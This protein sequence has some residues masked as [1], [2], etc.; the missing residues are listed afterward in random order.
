MRVLVTGGAGFIGRHV[1]DALERHDVAVLDAATDG[2]VR[3]AEALDD[4]LPGVD[5]V[6]HLAA[7]VGLGVDVQDLPHYADANVHG[8]AQLLAAMARADVGRLV[9]ASSMVVYGEG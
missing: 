6:I 1:C 5:A 3:D 7:K 9:L 8:T 4:M 2:D